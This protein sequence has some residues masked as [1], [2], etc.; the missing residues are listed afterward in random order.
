MSSCKIVP[1]AQGARKT[2]DFTTTSADFNNAL[3]VHYGFTCLHYFIFMDINLNN[4]GKKINIEKQ[5][6]K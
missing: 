2:W 4:T 5:K 3:P 6:L 1:E